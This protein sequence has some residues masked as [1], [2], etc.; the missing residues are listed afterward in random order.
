MPQTRVIS[1]S[2]SKDMLIATMPLVAASWR[3]EET[4][5][6]KGHNSA[7]VGADGVTAGCTGY[8]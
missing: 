7:L 3:C 6:S 1:Q 4:W 8:A 5:R 2:S